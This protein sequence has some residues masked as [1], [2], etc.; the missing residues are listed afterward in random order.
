MAVTS[1]AGLGP[2]GPGGERP[3]V[4][5]PKKSRKGS[6][7][8]ATRCRSAATSERRRSLVTRPGE[9]RRWRGPPGAGFRSLAFHEDPQESAAAASWTGQV[10]NTL[11]KQPVERAAAPRTATD[12]PTPAPGTLRLASGLQPAFPLP[13][14]LARATQRAT[15]LP[16]AGGATA[17]A[18]LRRR[19]GYYPGS[20]Y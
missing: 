14:H 17:V 11:P 20:W 19:L 6:S 2:E 5:I 16:P 3:A 4:G 13:S 15:E 9:T 8:G 12:A 7:W 1:P 10:T 18:S